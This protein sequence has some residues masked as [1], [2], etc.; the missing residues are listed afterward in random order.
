MPKDAKRT[1]KLKR[2]ILI[3][4]EHTEKGK[5]V[6]LDAEVAAG[7]VGENSAEYVDLKAADAEEVRN[8][9]PAAQSRD[10]KAKKA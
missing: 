10:P 9:D 3:D 8:N 2:H 6:S 1:V 5:V 7:L 4:G